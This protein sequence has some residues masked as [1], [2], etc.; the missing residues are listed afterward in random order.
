VTPDEPHFVSNTPGHCSPTALI[1]DDHPSRKIL[2]IQDPYLDAGIGDSFAAG[3]SFDIF[4]AEPSNLATRNEGLQDFS[5][6]LSQYDNAGVHLA[7]PALQTATDTITIGTTIGWNKSHVPD[8]FLIDDFGSS[9]AA[10]SPFDPSSLATGSALHY[11]SSNFIPQS[12]GTEVHF[13]QF[14]F[15]A[16]PT[17]SIESEFTCSR[18][19]KAFK[20][21]GDLTRHGKS[22]GP[23]TFY[24]IYANCPRSVYTKGF[25]RKDKLVDH[26]ESSH[27][28]TKEDAKRWAT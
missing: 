22:H 20:R 27:K 19:G 24:C 5:D 13:A 11:D 3:P 6:W 1:A 21:K 15:H 17:T 18:C 16:A 8:P 14:A 4:N 28:M 12:V 23:T 2:P 26:L 7:Q 10:S 9:Y 25:Y